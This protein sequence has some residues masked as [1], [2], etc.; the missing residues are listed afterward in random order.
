MFLIEVIPIARLPRSL[1]ESFSYFS[2]EPAP[3][4]A[5]A[6]ITVQS[7]TLLALV[8]TSSPVK[9]V[10]Q[11][12]RNASFVVR[13]INRIVSPHPIFN[14]R[15]MAFMQWM[16]EFYLTNPATILRMILPSYVTQKTN[17]S[18]WEERPEI[19]RQERSTIR[20]FAGPGYRKSYP[21]IAREALGAE[22][23]CLVVA[24]EIHRSEEI[25]KELKAAIPSAGIWHI[26]GE[27]TPKALA[28]VWH[29]IRRGEPGII[30]GTR[31]ALF[32]PYQK[33]STIIVDN[34]SADSHKSWDQHPRYH[35]REIA[36]KLHDLHGGSLVFAGNPPSLESYELVKTESRDRRLIILPELK[37]EPVSIFVDMQKEMKETGAF[38]VISQV[39]KDKLR[40]ILADRGRAFLFVNRKGF[41][42]FI[43]C[44]E[45]AHVF[46]CAN[47]AVPLVYHLQESLAKPTLLCHQCSAKN[48][49]PD[50][51][52]ICSSSK[53]K[54]YGIGI[55]RVVRELREL[56]PE[57]EVIP[58]SALDANKKTG[59][60]R[61]KT[62]LEKQ[63]YIA[64][65]TEF[66]LTALTL[67]R[68][69]LAAIISIDTALSLPDYA[70]NERLFRTLAQIRQIARKHFILQSYAKEPELLQDLFHGT[71]QHFAE[72]ELK[73][74]RRF[75]YPPYSELVKLTVMNQNRELAARHIKLVYQHAKGLIRVFGPEAV[76]V[77]NPYPAYVEKK[78]GNFIFHVLVKILKPSMVHEIKNRLGTTLPAEVTID[79]GPLTLL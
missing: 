18:E 68:V 78:Q 33:L 41:A 29:M 15:D 66:A 21:D 62:A 31:S 57:A 79:V 7:R 44:Q 65:G 3:V 58:V 72:K 54:P 24:P 64:V 16:C 5:I 28:S 34:D 22:A 51:C 39:I 37:P 1:P 10:K 12:L 70:Q 23:Q 50:I 59:L 55:E 63:S 40:G 26:T 11:Q 61:T 25:A 38:V 30:V 74:R 2:Q 6:E 75:G 45:C 56:F 42:P 71:F 48:P 73:D 43:L 69:D 8:V 35:V 36:K 9:N 27:K 67:P 32:F 13:K 77:S 20:V 4:G 52:P 60:R 19:E 47:C 46:R 53:L 14:A 49:A 17:F 76:E